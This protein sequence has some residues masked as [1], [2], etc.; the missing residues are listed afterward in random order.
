[1]PESVTLSDTEQIGLALIVVSSVE[2]VRLQAKI[3]QCTVHT[4]RVEGQEISLGTIQTLSHA[5]VQ[6]V[7][8]HSL[9]DHTNIRSGS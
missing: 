9:I 3:A 5:I 6:L 8:K 7:T 2:R 1:M 4:L